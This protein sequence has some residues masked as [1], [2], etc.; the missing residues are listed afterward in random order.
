M[1]FLSELRLSCELSAWIGEVGRCQW[2]N[3]TLPAKGG[4]RAFCSSACTKTF[5]KNH[6]W[7][8][9][10]R[11]AKKRA[12]YRCI[13]PGCEDD[14]GYIEV[15]HITPLVG[16]GYGPSCFHHEANL[17]AICKPHHQIETNRQ[18]DERKVEKEKE[19]DFQALMQKE[20]I[21]KGFRLDLLSGNQTVEL[22]ELEEYEE[23]SDEI[24][25]EGDEHDLDEKYKLEEE[26]V[27]VIPVR[28]GPKRP[29]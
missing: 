7:A 4:R 18:R 29:F 1:S 5:E 2:C 16:Q 11:G 6:I 27:E 23:D 19:K 9:A 14:T 21:V 28:V 25:D 20:E 12:K 13:R 15:N 17:E 22:P 24:I 26:F 10:R 3:N 8:L